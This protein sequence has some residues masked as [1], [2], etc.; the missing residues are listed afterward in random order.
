MRRGPLF[1]IGMMLL[2]GV[3]GQVDDVRIKGHF[4]NEATNDTLSRGH[5]TV[6]DLEGHRKRSISMIQPITGDVASLTRGEHV[7]MYFSAPG[8]KTRL[9]E[10]DLTGAKPFRSG[11]RYTEVYMDIG[12]MPL[13]DTTHADTNFRRLGKCTVNG[14]ALRWSSDAEAAAFPIT[15]RN[16]KEFA[17]DRALRKRI[18]NKVPVAIFGAVKDEWTHAPITGALVEWQDDGGNIDRLN[19]GAH[20]DY[21]LSL[22]FD[23]LYTVTYSAPGMLSKRVVVDTRGIPD[24]DRLGGFG[25][26][27]DIRLFGALSGEDLSFLDEPIGRAVWSDAIRNMMWEVEYTA[28]RLE[29][30]KTILDRHRR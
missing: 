18:A 3:L 14:S 30:L 24:Q 22:E 26:N 25:M 13:K 4:I 1:I 27:V 12:L 10:F 19:T 23:R 7:M 15:E 29:R 21:T 16:E 6:I 11:G 8:F 2:S 17:T 20:G 9:A 5:V 28:P